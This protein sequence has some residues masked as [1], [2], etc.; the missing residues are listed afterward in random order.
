[1]NKAEFKTYLVSNYNRVGNLRIAVSQNDFDIRKAEMG[2]GFYAISVDDLI[3]DDSGNEISKTGTVFF[4]VYDEDTAQEKVVWEEKADPTFQ[5]R[6][7]DET[8]K[9]MLTAWYKNNKPAEIHRFR[10]TSVDIE[11]QFA[12]ADVYELSGGVITEGRVFIQKNGAVITAT[13]M[14]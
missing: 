3:I 14:S 13:K 5:Q 1:M 6:P 7:A 9:I 4:K 12:I 11:L 2:Y 10:I 8:V